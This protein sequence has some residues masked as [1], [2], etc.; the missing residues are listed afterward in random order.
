MPNL[1]GLILPTPNVS[2]GWGS[3]LNNDLTIIDNVFADNGSG[4][5]VG[6]QVGTGKTLN[7]G[8][9]VIAG[10]TMILGSGDGTNTVAAPTIRGAARTGTNAAGPDLTIDA[11]N[12]TGTGGSGKVIFRTAPAGVAGITANTMASRLEINSAGAIGIAGANYGSANQVLLS[13]G[14]TTTPS[15]SNVNGSVITIPSQA[16]GD[17]LYR[18]ASAWERLPAGTNGQLLRT[19]G[20]AAN[21]SWQSVPVQGTSQA[22][23]GSSITF[24]SIPA[25]AKMITIPV[26]QMGTASSADVLIRLGTSS[27]VVTTGYASTGSN[28][29][30]D[31]GGG[32][33]DSATSTVGFLINLGS[34]IVSGTIRITN[35][36]GNTWVCDHTLGS[37]TTAYSMFGG[38]RITLSGVLDRVQLVTTSGNFDAAGSAN[39][40][41]L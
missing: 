18:G 32:D 26:A 27:G 41:Y 11:L 28:F 21:P 5:S 6:L 13:G 30:K 10:G 24:T 22:F 8:G 17:I 9:T 38:G 31:S 29:R 16:Q 40:L 1:A 7:A 33:G 36:S 35:I 23:S 2:T 34:L 15:W 25:T 37:E 14:S 20:A 3:T 39:I 4:T 19:N 12:G